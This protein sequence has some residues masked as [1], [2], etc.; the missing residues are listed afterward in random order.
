MAMA[1]EKLPQNSLAKP[2]VYKL[3]NNYISTFLVDMICVYL[4]LVNTV[5]QTAF[6][7]TRVG[8]IF[9]VA[10]LRQVSVTTFQG[11]FNRLYNC[12]WRF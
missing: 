6:V 11:K 2:A 8:P 4:L 12:V 3:L 10:T 5:T 7:T 9:I 1:S